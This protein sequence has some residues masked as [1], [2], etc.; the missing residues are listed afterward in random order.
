M[1][2][3]IME[4]NHVLWSF[5]S[6]K[7]LEQ[8]WGNPLFVDAIIESWDVIEAVQIREF[9]RAKSRLHDVFKPES[10]YKWVRCYLNTSNF[11]RC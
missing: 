6:N 4:S 2:S 9:G 11:F 7:N 3:L 8:G 10:G 5:P 1:L